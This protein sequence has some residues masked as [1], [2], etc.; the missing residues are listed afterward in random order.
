MSGF[1]ASLNQGEIGECL[2]YQAH[3]GKLE[4]IDGLK[5]DFI[6]KETGQKLELKTDLWKMADTPN[7]F[8][9]RW[10]DKKAGKPGGPW[11]SLGHGCELFVYLYV[12]D[13]TYFTFN[14][15]QLVGRLE[16]IIPKLAATPVANKTWTTEGYRVPRS[17][18]EDIAT[19]GRIKVG[20]DDDSN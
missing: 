7:F 9:E 10:S 15:E 12:K 4:K 19:V 3:D 16:E 1:K 5:G 2:F 18:L 8:I 14:T 17:A 13:L 6:W 20:L 11:Q